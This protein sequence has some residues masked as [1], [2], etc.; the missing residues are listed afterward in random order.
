MQI[1]NIKFENIE[2]CYEIICGNQKM[3][4][5]ANFGPRILYFGFKNGSNILFADRDSKVTYNNWKIYGGHRLW[6]SPEAN[7]TYSPDNQTVQVLKSENA[8]QFTFND[9]KLQLDRTIKIS[10]KNKRF[11]VE[12]IVENIGKFLYPGAIWALTCVNPI[13]TVFLPWNSLGHW[14]MSKIIYWQNWAGH[15]SKITSSQ[16]Q[17]TQDLFLIKANGEEGKVGTAGYEGFIGITT[18]DYTFIKK[19]NRSL[20]QDYPDDN[21]AIEC[22]TSSNF[23]ELETLSPNTIFMP[24]VPVSHTEEWILL[25][26]PVNTNNNSEIKKYL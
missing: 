25:D 22:Y 21:C 20:T 7:D 13:G 1:N 4:I 17:K 16:Y 23:I 8:I 12:H 6:I 19:F 10:E 3:I 24:G 5:S 18:A 14:T 11:Q 26:K 15:T 9:E 2:N